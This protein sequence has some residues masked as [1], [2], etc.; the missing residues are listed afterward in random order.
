MQVHPCALSDVLV[1]RNARRLTPSE[2]RPGHHVMPAEKLL[3]GIRFRSGT[4][5][6]LDIPS[7]IIRVDNSGSLDYANILPDIRQV[8]PA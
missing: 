6:P 5:E 8:A 4:W 1:E 3:E 2:Q 7:E